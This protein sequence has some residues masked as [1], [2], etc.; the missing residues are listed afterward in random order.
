MSFPG[1]IEGPVHSLPDVF[2]C[3]CSDLR[4]HELAEPQEE[5]TQFA[6]SSQWSEVAWRVT[7]L[8]SGF[9]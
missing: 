4:C 1:S 7:L 5:Y 3:W 6:G 2:L 8:T 9:A